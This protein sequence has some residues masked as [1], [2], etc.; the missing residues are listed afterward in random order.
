[1]VFHAYPHAKKADLWHNKK[2]FSLFKSMTMN[3]QQKGRIFVISAASGTGKTTL[4]QRI[5]SQNSD[6]RVSVSHTTRAP[7]VGEENGVHYYFTDVES[8]QNMIAQDAFLEHAEVF[9]NFYGTSIE[10]VKALSESGV[11]VILEID[12]QGAH[13]VREKLPESVLIFIL[14]PSMAL[15]E[16]RLRNRKTDSEE[17]IVRRLGEAAQ[18]I[19]QASGFDYLVVNDDLDQAECDLMTIIK[20]E[21]LNQPNKQDIIEKLLHNQ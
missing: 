8:F 1:M 16:Q 19:S 13:Q 3:T 6:I 7:R 9:G 20:A 15:L 5:L 2:E 21:R 4:V 17:V 10:G 12:V 18:E 11:D 14:P